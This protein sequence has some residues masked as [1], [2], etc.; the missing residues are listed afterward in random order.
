MVN[1]KIEKKLN[2]NVRNSEMNKVE[3]SALQPH[4]RPFPKNISVVLK[5]FFYSKEIICSY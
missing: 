5:I 4:N 3:N 1:C 2:Q